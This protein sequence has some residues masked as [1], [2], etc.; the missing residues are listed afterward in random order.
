MDT[1]SERALIKAEIIAA[2][3][4]FLFG[5]SART[6]AIRVAVC[7]MARR[8]LASSFTDMLRLKASF[9]CNSE[10]ERQKDC[11]LGESFFPQPKELRASRKIDNRSE[12]ALN[13]LGLLALVV[14]GFELRIRVLA[15]TCTE[16]FQKQEHLLLRPMRPR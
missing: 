5:V 15:H 7:P 9:N 6:L 16:H 2:S 3:F 14:E 13:R 12:G 1:A 11:V 8:T 4:W 10:I